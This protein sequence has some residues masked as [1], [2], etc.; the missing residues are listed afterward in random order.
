M[1][2]IG[3][4]GSTGSGKSIVAK[5][6]QEYNMLVIDSD[7]IAHEIIKKGKPAYNELIT[8]FGQAIL[9]DDLEIDRKKLGKIVF[10]DKEKLDK[11]TK[12]THKHIIIEIKNII[13]SNKYNEAI[14][15]LVIDA[16]LLVEAGLHKI[17]DEVWVVYSEVDMR[18]ARI[19]NRDHI[20]REQAYNRINSQ[21]KWEELSKYADVIIVNNS[22]IENVINQVNTA[23]GDRK[24]LLS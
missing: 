9:E 21:M 13:N 6:L 11:L 18:L 19:M 14:K 20:T 3:L 10:S 7:K 12:C 16:P 23:L 8:I 5:C 24:G 4:T 15:G 22:T 1:I 2:I 17:V